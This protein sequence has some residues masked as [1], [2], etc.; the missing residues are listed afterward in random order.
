MVTTTQLLDAG[1]SLVPVPLGHKGPIN[2]G[3][4]LPD[5]CVFNAS[6]LSR[7]DGRN[8]GLAHAYCTPVPTCALDID[9]YK[10]AK[11]WLATHRINL[12]SLLFAGDAVV[13][14]SGKKG[15]LKLIYRLPRGQAPLESKKINGINGRSVLEF[16]CATK[17]GKTVQD[18]LPPS[19]HPE[20]YQYQWLGDGSPQAIPEI[21]TD[22]LSIWGLLIRNETRVARRNFGRIPS[23]TLRQESPR[24]IA[25][26]RSALGHITADCTYENWRN[27][28]WALLSTRW[29][30]AEDLAQEWSKSAPSRY[31]EDAFWTLVSSYLPDHDNPITV[32]TIYHHARAGGWNG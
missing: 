6:Q 20:G 5:Q 7:L 16:R 31:E 28:V 3:W 13:I 2:Q 15:S 10:Q 27:V 19:L 25:T 21:P 1:L 26:I 11:G 30:C 32:G 22:L 17:D 4:N 8:V 12:S 24:Q 23:L 9:N 14:W 29:S 18:L